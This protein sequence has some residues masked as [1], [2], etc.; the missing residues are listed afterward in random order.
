MKPRPITGRWFIDNP[1]VHFVMFLDSPETAKAA[2]ASNDI[3]EADDFLT[4]FN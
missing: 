1:L 4:K 2:L 3:E